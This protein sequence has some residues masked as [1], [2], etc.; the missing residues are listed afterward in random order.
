MLAK[1]IKNG[2][3]NNVLFSLKTMKNKETRGSEIRT[4]ALKEK[5]S[6]AKKVVNK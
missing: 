1:K 5:S 4:N 3:V 6:K 2:T